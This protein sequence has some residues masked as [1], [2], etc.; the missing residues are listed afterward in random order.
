[1]RAPVPAR[2][3][4]LGAAL[5]GAALL[6]AERS[7]PRLRLSYHGEP[8]R[9]HLLGRGRGTRGVGCGQSWLHRDVFGPPHWGRIGV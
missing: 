2:V 1:M 7:L 3:C 8:G 4:A 9:G 5:L 6:A